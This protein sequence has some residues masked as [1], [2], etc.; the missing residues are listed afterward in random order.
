VLVRHYRI[1][2]D[3][4]NA[5]AVWKR[6]G[7]PQSPTADQYATL[8]AAG[9]LQMLTSPEWM[10]ARAGSAELQFSLPAHAV[11]LIEFNW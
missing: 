8:E 11:S 1:D 6:M 7:S 2:D 9:Q 5:F 3:H 4:S 10:D